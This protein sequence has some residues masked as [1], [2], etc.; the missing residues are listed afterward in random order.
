MGAVAEREMASDL[1]THVERVWVHV[2]VRVAVGGADQH[3][4]RAAGWHPLALELRVLGDGTADMRR[5]R[6]EPEDLL[7]RVPDQ[8]RVLDERM[9]LVGMLR[10]QLRRPADQPVR[11]LVPG[12][13]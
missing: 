8:R 13:G 2:L 7:D 4:E 10:E 11:R 9:S 6:F 1:P 12:T 3:Q 5:G